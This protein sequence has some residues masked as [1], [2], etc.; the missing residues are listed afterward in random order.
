ML[1][2]FY[3]GFTIRPWHKNITKS[4]IKEPKFYLS[5][6][7][8]IQDVDKKSENFIAC[9]LI[10]AINFWNESGNG[11]YGMYYLRDKYQ[12]E[13]DF[14]ITKNDKLWFIA[15]VKHSNNSGISKNLEY[16][17]KMTN[18]EHA[19]QLIIDMPPKDINCFDFTHPIKIPAKTFLSQLP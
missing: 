9:H 12:R 19:F 4:I 18:A 16:F 5:D 15:E 10:K 2:N 13:V 6:W 8:N 14:A 7:S 17:Q 11:E 1:E 3:Y